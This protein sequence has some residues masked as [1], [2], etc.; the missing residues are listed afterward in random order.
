MT[1]LRAHAT[2]LAAA[3]CLVLAAPAATHAA[4]FMYFKDS[5]IVGEMPAPPP[6]LATPTQPRTPTIGDGD[7]DGRD[8]LVWQRG[9][10]PTPKARQPGGVKKLQA[11]GSMKTK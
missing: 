7:T 3:L 1:I 10:S 4:G 2:P 5:P 6:P 8:F 11:P 9:A